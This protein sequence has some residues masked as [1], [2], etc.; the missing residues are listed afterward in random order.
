MSVYLSRILYIKVLVLQILD[1]NK[2]RKQ[3]SQWYLSISTF[4]KGWLH[5]DTTATKQK[6]TQRVALVEDDMSVVGAEYE[7]LIKIETNRDH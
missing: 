5:N 2:M 4:D 3:I 1:K 7:T 6:S